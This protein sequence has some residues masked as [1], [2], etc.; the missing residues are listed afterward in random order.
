MADHFVRQARAEATELGLPP[1]V[2]VQCAVAWD[3]T[4]LG[5]QMR[6]QRGVIKGGEIFGNLG[7]LDERMLVVVELHRV[8]KVRRVGP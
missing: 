5:A 4:D 1:S 6:N 2:K 3:D 7:D 8:H